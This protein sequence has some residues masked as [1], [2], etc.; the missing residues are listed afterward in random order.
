MILRSSMVSDF[1]SCPAKAAYKYEVGITPIQSGRSND[2][3]FGSLV[4]QAIEIYHN[5][6]LDEAVSLIENSG[7]SETRRKNRSTA[8]ALL[9]TYVSTNSVQMERTESSFSFKIGSHTWQGRF[10][11]IG[12]YNGGRWVLEHKTTQPNYLI[13]KPND[14]FVA[15]WLG[16][17]IYYHDIQGVLVNSLDCDKLQVTRYPVTFSRDEKEE[18]ITEMKALAE[19]YKRYRSKGIFPRNPGACFAFNRLC[20]YYPLC[21]EPDSSRQVIVEKCYQENSFV[22][23]MEW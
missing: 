22:K 6:S 23:N 19:T 17:F 21:Q 16:G 5:H 11:G 20:P 12:W 1:K 8:K 15:Y 2:L 9:K 10:D 7:M 4:H 18:W 14:Q 3:E 13:L